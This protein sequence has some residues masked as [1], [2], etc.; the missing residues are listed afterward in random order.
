V[1]WLDHCYRDG[2][3]ALEDVATGLELTYY[4][5]I[6]HESP[7]AITMSMESVEGGRTRN[8]FDILKQN[9]IEIQ[10]LDAEKVF[11]AKRPKKEKKSAKIKV[12]E[13]KGQEAAS[14]DS[15][16]NDSPPDRQ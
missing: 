2:E 15:R 14:G 3:Y 7:I 6:V 1:R 4:G 13:N 12:P 5:L 9:I 10:T 11:K 8:P 16:G